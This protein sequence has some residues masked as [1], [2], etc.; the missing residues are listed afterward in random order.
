MTYVIFIPLYLCVIMALAIYLKKKDKL[1][2]IKG[3]NI[4]IVLFLLSC[5]ALFNSLGLFINLAL[6]V[7]NRQYGG[8]AGLVVGGN[9]WLNMIWLELPVL[10]FLTVFLGIRLI[11]NK[12]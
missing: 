7:S 4:D 10:F 8:G 11:R 9:F 6:Y 5:T 2:F 1:E 3:K 12:K